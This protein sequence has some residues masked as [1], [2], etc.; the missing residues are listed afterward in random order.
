MFLVSGE[1]ANVGVV[2]ADQ[3][4]AGAGAGS[5]SEHDR[6]SERSDD[7]SSR[8]SCSAD[9][10]ISNMLCVSVMSSVNSASSCRN[11]RVI[12]VIK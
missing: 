2:S 5:E 8:E 1:V 4:G 11:P 12:S 7:L 3:D 6:S 9:Q 10:V